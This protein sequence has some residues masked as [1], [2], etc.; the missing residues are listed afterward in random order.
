MKDEYQLF[1]DKFKPKLTTDDC[2]TPECIYQ[3][4]LKWTGERYGVRTEDVVRPF[5]P[6]GDYQNFHYPERCT[7]VDNPP[8]SIFK[9]IVV[10]YVN[11]GIRFFLFA[12][13]LTAMGVVASVKPM[14]VTLIA[15][16]A[17]VTYANGAVVNTSFVTN[18]DCPDVIARSEP[19]LRRRICEVNKK[20]VKKHK[21][22]IRKLAYPSC[23]VTGA[24]MNRL[25]VYGV[26]Y[27]VR[28]SQCCFVR[29]LDGQKQSI[30]GG[31]LLLSERAAAER[32]AAERIILSDRE[33]EIQKMLT[34]QEN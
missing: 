1:V 27:A 22:T 3:E 7:V 12:P 18:L 17:S 4:V 13:G 14:P 24:S 32:A 11:H 16:G 29:K 8:F 28:S 25:S 15:A 21:K 30:F 5:Y 10:F 33:I 6:G 20:N 2:Y 23:V 9:Q 34:E 19:E 26:E 31:G